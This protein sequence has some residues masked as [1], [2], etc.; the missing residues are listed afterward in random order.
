MSL[1]FSNPYL[2]NWVS[3]MPVTATGM[4]WVLWLRFWAVTKT[5]SSMAAALAALDAAAIA[6]QRLL[7]SSALRVEA[8]E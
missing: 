7:L 3:V 5:S 4:S 8:D 2:S 1:A 6:M